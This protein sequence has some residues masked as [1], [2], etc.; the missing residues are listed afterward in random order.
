MKKIPLLA[1]AFLVVLGF[2]ACGNPAS[3]DSSHSFSDSSTS[4][5]MMCYSGGISDAA[6]STDSLQSAYYTGTPSNATF[7]F[8]NYVSGGITLNGSLSYMTTTSPINTT[9]INGTLR[10]T[11]STSVS[12]IIYSNV[13]V[14]GSALTGTLTITYVDGSSWSYNYATSTFTRT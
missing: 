1:L 3:G 14:A 6:L 5:A 7:H 2:A 4:A 13:G 8:S 12:K 10:F 9:S 11:G